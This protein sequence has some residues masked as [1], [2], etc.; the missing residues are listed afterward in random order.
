[1]QW[2]S[3]FWHGKTASVK[4]RE[5]FY[6]KI[7]RGKSWASISNTNI[8]NKSHF[9]INFLSFFHSAFLG[10]KDVYCY[11]KWKSKY[12]KPNKRSRFNEGLWEIENNPD[13]LF[14]GN[15][16]VWFAVH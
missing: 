15:V 10:P 6:K 7:Q 9:Y 14:R 1:M 2:S 5:F 3:S 12:G 13:V 8:S 16:S 4:W 11:E